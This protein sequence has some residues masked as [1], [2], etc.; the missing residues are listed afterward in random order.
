MATHKFRIGDSVRVFTWWNSKY[1]LWIG[2]VTDIRSRYNG[3]FWE[4]SI[5]FHDGAEYP[6]W[7]NE[8]MLPT[9][10]PIWLEEHG[11]Y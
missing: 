5:V 3:K 8:L 6:F 10:M 11:R 2:R 7:E 1:D 9:E 4:Y